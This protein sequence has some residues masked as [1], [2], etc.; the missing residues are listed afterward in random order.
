MSRI[1]KIGT[2]PNKLSLWQAN[3]VAKQLNYFEHETEIVIIETLGDFNLGSPKYELTENDI[4]T[5]NIDTALL[6]EKIDI[7]VHALKEVSPNLKG[8]IVQAAVL[9]RGDYNDVLVLKDNDDFFS[10]KVATIATE[11]LRCKSQWLYRYPNHKVV[12]ISGSIEEQLQKLDD[13]D[14]DGVIFLKSDLKRLELLPKN[15]LKLDWILPAPAQGT[16]VI[17]ARENDSD[18]LTICKELNDHETEIFVGIERDFL[19]TL[20]TY[21]SSPVAALATI[22]KE[23]TLKFKAAIYSVDGKDKTD[24]L[25]EVPVDHI[26]DIG[27]YAAKFLLKRGGKKL[28]RKEINIDKEILVYSTKALSLTQRSFF[29]ANIGVKMSDFIKIRFNRL[30]PSLVKEPLKNIV[31]VD[32]N[33]V[34]SV[35]NNFSSD[36]LNFTNIYC[37]SRRTK[38]FIEKNI[39]KVT[40]YEKTIEKLTDYL[41][42]NIEIKEINLFCGVGDNMKLKNIETNKIECYRTL[43]SSVKVNDKFKGILFYSS[44]EIESYLFKNKADDKIAFCIGISTAS[45]AAKHFKNVITAKLPTVDSLIKSVNSYFEHNSQ[46]PNN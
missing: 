17:T 2:R 42:K 14:W 4:F 15:H 41:E 22:N 19:R 33:A 18:M 28:M 3:T 13:N 6:D 34:E 31:F 1:I 40:H 36:E 25:K 24:F 9:K 45:E 32:K 5:Q 11:S 29:N 46:D 27:E 43:Q 35:L 21:R 12:G 16:V 30:K 39:G 23:E 8:G 37:V 44:A 20:D 7:A 10:D 38:R 26:S